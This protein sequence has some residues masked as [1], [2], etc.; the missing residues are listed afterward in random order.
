MA[1]SVNEAEYT[2]RRNE[3]LDAAQQLVYTKGYEQM[4]IQDI[5]TVTGMSKG[6]FYHYFDSKPAMLE[7]LIERM[8]S[9]VTAVLEPIVEDPSLDALQKLD[10]YFAAANNWK[11]EHKSYLLRIFKVWY[12]DENAIVREKIS[13]GGIRWI[14]PMLAKIVRQGIA[15]GAFD[16]PFPEHAGLFLIRIFESLGNTFAE[17]LL[18]PAE[19]NTREQGMCKIMNAIE[20]HTDALE[21]VLGAARGSLKIMNVDS[22]RTW[23]D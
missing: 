14:S 12:A 8:Q 2:T 9:E 15:E 19:G 7:A 5:L 21:R 1:R 22:L 6:A 4:T 16:T 13:T 11:I 17:V 20:A 3:I 10:R 23:L 18:S